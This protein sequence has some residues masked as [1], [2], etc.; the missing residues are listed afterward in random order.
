MNK[1]LVEKYCRQAGIFSKIVLVAAFSLSCVPVI[2]N[3]P[4]AAI[5]RV[6]SPIPAVTAEG[7]DECDIGSGEFGI[8]GAGPPA[9]IKNRHGK[10]PAGFV[11]ASVVPLVVGQP[12]GWRI[13]VTPP[14]A[15]VHWKEEFTLPA[16]PKTWG[17]VNPDDSDPPGGK[18]Q[19]LEK[20]GKACVSEKDV[21]AANGTIS[22]FWSVAK[23]DPPGVYKMRVWVNGKLAK[24]FEFQVKTQSPK[25][26]AAAEEKTR[27][28][29]PSAKE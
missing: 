3:S 4:C 2:F 7:E 28:Q 16:V 27:E 13:H 8:I 25:A 23:G 15:F 17:G 11:A 29:Q 18:Q 21:R 10:P 26:K 22:N 24:T 14:D 20:G 19:M 5:P 9:G 1:Q 6:D 12:Y